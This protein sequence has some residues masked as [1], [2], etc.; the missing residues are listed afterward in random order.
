MSHH[1]LA[2][3]SSANDINLKLL[4]LAL[5]IFFKQGQKVATFFTKT[6]QE[7]SQSQLLILF[8]SESIELNP[9]SP[10]GS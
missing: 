7:W 3:I 6:P 4:N 5:G 8:P 9:H 10:Q 1:H 2:K